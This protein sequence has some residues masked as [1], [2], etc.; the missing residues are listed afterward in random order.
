MARKDELGRAGEQAAESY[1]RAHG[2]EILDRNWRCRAGELDL[3]VADA[4]TIVVVEVKTCRSAAFGH[5]FEAIDARKLHRLHQLARDWRA[6]HRDLAGS[7]RLRVDALAITGDPEAP[8]R[9]E[10]LRDLA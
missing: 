9:I 3:V 2:F 10:H 5:P 7:R 6:A 8:V 1:L 4:D